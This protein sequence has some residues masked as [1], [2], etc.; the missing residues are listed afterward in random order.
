MPPILENKKREGVY[1]RET[2]GSP[3]FGN[4]AYTKREEA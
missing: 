4:G 2:S 3:L 1:S